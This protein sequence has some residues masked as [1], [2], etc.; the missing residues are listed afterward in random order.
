MAEITGAQLSRNLSLAKLENFR[1][2][3]N[4]TI[5][6][7]EAYGWASFGTGFAAW[8]F[9]IWAVLMVLMRSHLSEI[10]VLA[11]KHSNIKL[12]NQAASMIALSVGI[13]AFSLYTVYSEEMHRA[14]QE[15]IAQSVP[16]QLAASKLKSLEEELQRIESTSDLAQI[17]AARSEYQDLQKRLEQAQQP[18][19]GFWQR[20]HKNGE[21]YSNIVDQNTLAAKPSRWGGGLM[22]SARNEI[23]AQWNALQTDVQSIKYQIG[24]I[25][26]TLKA[27]QKIEN[28]RTQVNIAKTELLQAQTQTGITLNETHTH[29]PVFHLLSEL[30]FGTI[31]PNTIMSLFGIAAILL[32]LIANNVMSEAIAIAPTVPNPTTGDNT[33][34]EKTWYN[35][36][37]ELVLEKIK[38][39]PTTQPIDQPIDPIL[40]PVMATAHSQPNQSSVPVV[41]P[42]VPSTELIYSDKPTTTVITDES[43]NKQGQGFIG[44]IPPSPQPTKPKTGRKDFDL[45]R[46]QQVVSLLEKGHSVSE[47]TQLIGVARS[48]AYNDQKRWKNS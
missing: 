24:Q 11:F 20:K 28:L 25:N 5:A 26:N 17:A 41:E 40:K 15:R 36:L 18:S 27:G 37:T 35:K 38:P 7:I 3:L 23:V 39:S 34:T 2:W 6:A 42:I 21:L 19:Q 30:T 33:P 44:F 32:G 47:I 29:H 46:Y 43:D 13:T 31:S 4:W 14:N 1:S 45:Q 10:K 22:L 9:A 8:G 16:V 12:A 48:T